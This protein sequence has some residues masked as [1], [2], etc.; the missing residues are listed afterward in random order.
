MHID[1]AEIK[2]TDARSIRARL[3]G[4][5]D[6]LA[7]A[8]VPKDVYAPTR[9]MTEAARERLL[10]QQRRAKASAE[11]LARVDA[12]LASA[13]KSTTAKTI[14]MEIAAKHG[15]TPSELMGP[16]RKVAFVVARKEAAYEMRVQMPWMSLQQIGA[17]LGGR[18]YTTILYSIRSHAEANGLPIPEA[19]YDKHRKAKAAR[20]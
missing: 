12:W 15:I 6:P 13:P 9:Q 19:D 5:P 3:W 7:D 11:Y 18:D 1:P 10:L 17:R 2:I 16:S 4:R 14:I 20:A 8:P